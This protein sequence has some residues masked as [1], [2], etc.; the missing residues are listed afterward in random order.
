MLTRTYRN[1]ASAYS[2]IENRQ[3]QY[4]TKAALGF[5]ELHEVESVV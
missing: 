2:A 5:D 4:V 3:R 1:R